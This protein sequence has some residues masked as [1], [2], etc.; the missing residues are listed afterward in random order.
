[1]SAVRSARPVALVTGS[2]SGIGAACAKRLGAG[3]FNVTVNYASS[4]DAAQETAF[5][6]RAGGAETLVLQADVA[7][8]IACRALVAHTVDK[9]GRLDVLVN[10]AGITKFVDIH[11]LGG[12][13]ADDFARIFSVNVTAAYEMSTA[14]VP[15]LKAS[16]YASIVNITSH[17]GV[18]GIGSSHAYAASKGA[19]NTLTLGLAR[20]LAPE[21]RVN[22]VC[23]GYVDTPWH[24]GKVEDPGE[25]EAYKQRFADLAPLKRLTTSDDVAEAANFFAT[26]AK[27]ITGV[28]L[29]VD[30]GTHL[31]VG[32]PQNT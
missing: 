25:L 18:S 7:D 21:I 9:W 11:D 23:P 26:G 2:A 27:A 4:A 16:S 29:V 24:S 14:A 12:L 1:M 3:G 13:D 17:A 15:H 30:G 32:S 19:L 5:D 31:T 8:P 10:N 6:C 28:I 20:A 22:A